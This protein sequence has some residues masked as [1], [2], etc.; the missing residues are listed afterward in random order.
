MPL[1]CL[2]P[3]CRKAVA[4]DDR[5]AGQPMRC[6]MCSATFL[7]PSLAVAAAPV[8]PAAPVP[9]A[10]NPFAGS[11]DG[12]DGPVPPWQ[13]QAAATAA[14]QGPEWPWLVQ[15]NVSGYDWRSVQPQTPEALRLAPG[16]H[17]VLRGLT[18]LPGALIVVFATLALAR[19]FVLLAQPEPDGM[20]L[21]LLIM[22]PMT[23]L[24]A[25]A[26]IVS[27][28]LCCLA[29]EDSKLRPLATAATAAVFF[30]ML[31]AMVAVFTTFVINK[32]M[33]LENNPGLGGVTKV[34]R[35][36]A[37]VGGAILL[38]GGG[39]VYLLFLRGVAR[40]FDNRR[41][42]QHLVWYLIFFSLSPAAALFLGLLFGGT[43]MVLGMGDKEVQ[44]AVLV[45][46]NIALFV[47]GAIVLAG[48]LLML[49]DVR[50]TIER[51]VLPAKA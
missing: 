13:K 25:A 23:V 50:S 24:G 46:H 9:A 7:A 36:L 8:A 48:F 20:K 43:A 35:V 1:N 37:T 39:A 38:V 42:A 26:A 11:P 3:K 51:A 45:V 47:L 10:A 12:Y 19:L 49:R 16:W 30:G 28:G 18:L 4:I 32:P 2:C 44:G 29:P 31:A 27:M 33:W 14:P 41:L 5:F 22:V 21:V 17:M 15:P 34:V 40:V 6:P